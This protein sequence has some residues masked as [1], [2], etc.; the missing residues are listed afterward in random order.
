MNISTYVDTVRS[1]V[2]QAA[3]LADEATQQIAARLGEAVESATRLALIEALSDAAATISADLAPT[4]VDL[5]MS[6][7]EPH[8]VVTVP[9]DNAQP[10]FLTPETAEPPL[11]ETDDEEP[12]ARISLRL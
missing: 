10:T 11:G 7:T 3:S 9:S 4:S 6:G 12:L 5:R 8:F 1:G 2:T